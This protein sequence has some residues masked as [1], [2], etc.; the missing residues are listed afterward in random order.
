MDNRAKINQIRARYQHSEITLDEAK[1]LVQP[2]LDEMNKK[3]KIIA[4]KFG[5]KFSDLTFNYVFR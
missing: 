2:L 3:G 1:S 4:K 5:K